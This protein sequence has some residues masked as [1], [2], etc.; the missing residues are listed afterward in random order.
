M[1][2]TD[3][4]DSL[5][6]AVASPGEFATYFPFTTNDDLAATLADALSESQLDGFLSR[7]NLDVESVTTDVELSPAQQ[8]L[9]VLYARG[10]IIVSRLL[11]LKTHTRYKAGPVEAEVE[12]AASVLTELLKET[13]ARK[14]QLLDDAK[15]GNGITSFLMVDMYV[16]KSMDSRYGDLGFSYNNRVFSEP[17]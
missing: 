6:R 8:A 7:V 13:N 9:V 17:V 5:K 10:R 16:S 1:D 2:L 11:N 12:Q 14:A 3:L 4:A 15:A